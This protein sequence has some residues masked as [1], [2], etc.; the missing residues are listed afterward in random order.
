MNDRPVEQTAEM[1]VDLTAVVL[2]VYD[3]RTGWWNPEHGELVPPETWAFLPTGEAFVTRTV[4][5]AGVFWLAWS[6]RSA[7]RRHRRLLGLWAP[8]T[9]IVAARQAAADTAAQ[10]AVRREA[11]ARSRERQEARYQDEL[12]AAIVAFLAFAPEHEELAATIAKQAAQRA[13]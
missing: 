9:T 6:P 10:R 11:G 12:T 2:D 7:S 13:A 5:S 8:E 4:K 3:S 1:A